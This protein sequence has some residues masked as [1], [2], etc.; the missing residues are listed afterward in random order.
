MNILACILPFAWSY[1]LSISSFRFRIDFNSKII[2]SYRCKG[3]KLSSN[4]DELPTGDL[5]DWFENNGGRVGF[6]HKQS[7]GDDGKLFVTSL[8]NKNSTLIT[9]PKSLCIFSNP[10]EM[11]VPVSQRNIEN[12]LS[13]LD[14]KQWRTR[15]AI[16]FLSADFDKF[17]QYFWYLTDN[18]VHGIPLSF[19]SE[20][21]R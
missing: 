2:K 10:N 1:L 12:F 3:L 18:K 19:N 20:E 21:L 15:L 13:S 11:S 7:L 17:D 8:I 6:K 9:V 16:L 4:N 5:I 14:E